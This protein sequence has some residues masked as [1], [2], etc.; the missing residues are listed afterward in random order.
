MPDDGLELEQLRRELNEPGAGRPAGPP[1]AAGPPGLRGFLARARDACDY[2]QAAWTAGTGESTG[3]STGTETAGMTPLP[4]DTQAEPQAV[5]VPPG[6]ED[7]TG[8]RFTRLWVLCYLGRRP[9]SRQRRAVW[10]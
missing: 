1:R 3:E 9:M 7:F 8:M 2:L 10:Q 6:L 5:P 4:H